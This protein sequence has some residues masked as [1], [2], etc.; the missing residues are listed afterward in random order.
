MCI[1]DRSYAD[2]GTDNGVAPAVKTY[3]FKLSSAAVTSLN[4]VVLA[5]TTRAKGSTVNVSVPGTL[6]IGDSAATLSDGGSQTVKN[7]DANVAFS[8]SDATYATV[9]GT[10]INI[11]RGD[12][13]STKDITFTVTY[14]NPGGSAVTE[15]VTLRI[16][17]VTVNAVTSVTIGG[18]PFANGASGINVNPGNTTVGGIQA[19]LSDTRSVFI[20][21]ADTLF[22][23]VPSTFSSTSGNL[24]FSGSTLAAVGNFESVINIP[25]VRFGYANVSPPNATRWDAAVKI[26]EVVVSSLTNVTFNGVATDLTGGVPNIAVAAGSPVNL[27]LLVAALSDGNSKSSGFAGGG[28]YP[29]NTRLALTK[30]SGSG[31]AVGNNQVTTAAAGSGTFRLTYSFTDSNSVVHT[32]TRDFTVTAS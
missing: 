28:S 10:T 17:A 16:P 26:N 32:A 3:K 29:N 15:N 31:T 25:N 21:N 30:I 6:S 24:T 22:S 4:S 23:N 12:I 18:T 9:T 11:L 1:R 13:G 7:N 14:T 2:Q 5:G 8:T 19:S 20:T 27:T